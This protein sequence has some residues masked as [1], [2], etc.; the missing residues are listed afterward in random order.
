[1]IHHDPNTL[2]ADKNGNGFGSGF[3]DRCKFTFAE[4]G[5]GIGF[6]D[7]TPIIPGMNGEGAGVGR[8][9]D[10]ADGDSRIPTD[11]THDFATI[12]ILNLNLTL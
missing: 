1:M 5:S 11:D 7:D 4:E 6:G 10:G 3:H 8:F 9:A 12:T 2:R